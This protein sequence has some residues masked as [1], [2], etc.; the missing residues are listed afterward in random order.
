MT[1]ILALALTR[2]IITVQTT[3][4]D[5]QMTTFKYSTLNKAENGFEVID[6]QTNKVIGFY[7]KGLKAVA[8]R[9]AHE[10]GM[11]KAIELWSKL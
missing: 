5:N 7:N 3:Q 11:L 2:A 6:T 1:L 9:V 10:E 8:K 4:R